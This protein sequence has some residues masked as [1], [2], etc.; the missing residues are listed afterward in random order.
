MILHF[1]MLPST[2]TLRCTSLCCYVSVSELL[3]DL[4]GKIFESHRMLHM[5]SLKVL[6][7]LTLK[8]LAEL[9]SNGRMLLDLI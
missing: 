9:S 2:D 4:C 1:M 8:L 3:C 7:N 5:H 6:T